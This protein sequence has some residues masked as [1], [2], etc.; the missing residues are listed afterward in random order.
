MNEWYMRVM[1]EF[2][3][4][5]VLERKVETTCAAIF[6]KFGSSAE[7]Y[8]EPEDRREF[9]LPP[10]DNCFEELIL[11]RVKQEEEL[12]PSIEPLPAASTS[13]ESG[14][15]GPP[16]ALATF[17]SESQSSRDEYLRAAEASNAIGSLSSVSGVNDV[18]NGQQ[19]KQ[20]ENEQRQQAPSSQIPIQMLV[21]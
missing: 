16:G 9:S 2:P 18:V 5:S 21:S 20:D 1:N 15:T 14:G 8:V 4:L 3:S 7:R 12:L 6:E 13:G 19:D 10:R 11:A 17:L